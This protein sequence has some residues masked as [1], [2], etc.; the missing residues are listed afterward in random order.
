M[1]FKR[2]QTETVEALESFLSYC[3]AEGP[4]RAFQRFNQAQPYRELEG[5]PGV[6]YVCLRLPTG[7]GKTILAAKS[8]QIAGKTLLR[9]DR[10]FTLWMVP[11]DPIKQQTIDAFNNTSHPYRRLLDDAFGGDVAIFDIENFADIRPVDIE[12]KACIVVSTIQAFRVE[13]TKDRAV[14]KHHE[15]LE[16][17]FAQAFDPTGLERVSAEEA[18]EKGLTAGVV[19]FS[20]ANLMHLV[21]PIMIVDEAHN[22]ISSLTTI[23][24]QRLRPSTVIEFTATPRDRNNVLHSVTASALKDEEMIKL[25]IILKVKNSWQEAVDDAVFKRNALEKI[26][27]KDKD[28]IRPIVLYQAQNSKSEAN[29]E[30]IKTYLIEERLVP[31]NRIAIATGTQRELDSIDLRSP[32]CTIDHIITIEAL[33]EGWDC[34]TAYV[35]C[36]T[37]KISSETKVEQLLGRVL[38]MPGAERR[39][40]PAL[41]RAYA[42]VS[43]PSVYDVAGQL[44]DKLL[45]MGF[46]D[47]EAVS[48]F[49]QS[50]YK[51]DD[52]TGDLFDMANE[53]AP[54]FQHTFEDT[55]DN[56]KAAEAAKED[57]AEIIENDNGTLTLAVTGA[58]PKSVADVVAQVTPEDKKAEVT[59]KAEAHQKKVEAAKSP[60]EKGIS[61]SVPGLGSLVQGELLLAHDETI[62]DAQPWTLAK[63]P[64]VL[65]EEELKLNKADGIIMIDLRGEK[66][67]YEE[68]LAQDEF[69]PGLQN[70]NVGTTEA[71][72][73]SILERQCRVESLPV[74]ELSRWLAGIVADLIS[75]RGMSVQDLVDW[76]PQIV[77]AIREKL[78]KLYE[79]SK[80]EAFQLALFSDT[81]DLKVIE[82]KFDFKEGVYADVPRHPLPPGM[83][84]SKHLLGERTIPRLDG[85]PLGEEM[86]CAK[87]LNSLDEVEVWVRNVASHPQAFCLI[88]SNGRLYYPDFIAKLVDG[89]IF[90][91]EYKGAAGA[92]RDDTRE[93][94]M[95]AQRWAKATG[96]VYA[97]IEK[98]KDG[99]NMQLQLLDA[100]KGR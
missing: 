16:P 74:S 78:R 1:Q 17:H 24:Q 75:T 25:P 35:L 36:A 7:G 96:N 64:A 19:K 60:A 69:L 59:K 6:P 66:V 84:L 80:K 4:A 23:T 91:V 93:K 38:R 34:P 37:Q 9:T 13:S 33:R 21:R 100:I 5:L 73:V 29:P 42:F 39:Q 44:R 94:A 83:I 2:Y 22:A 58:I 12:K 86:Q 30:D 98:E 89:R 77:A 90:V 76:E 43:D 97:V 68:K 63:E 41:N 67:V 14:Y 87:A 48:N 52:R 28:R 45:S 53:E 99:K 61:I 27:L 18:E 70:R 55:A 57:G 62:F 47:E 50:G 32:H 11:S 40:D 71:R 65:T 82:G 8:I 88:R 10:P 54:V 3:A 20:F 81:A 72:F 51:R 49:R 26:G 46:T 92:D 31:A 56:R 85:N 15:E 95:V 79:K